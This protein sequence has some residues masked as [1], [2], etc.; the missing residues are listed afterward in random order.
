MQLQTIVNVEKPVF[1]IGYDKR[2]LMLGSCF[3]EN[4][5]GKL[6]YFK[7]DVD[8]N[9]CGIVYNPLSVV[10]VLNMLLDNRLFTENDLLQN[11]GKWVS[12]SHHGRFSA[13][14]SGNC[15]RKINERLEGAAAHLRMTDVLMITWGTSGVYRFRKDGKIVSNCHKFPASDFERFRLDID[16]I[17]KEYTDILLRLKRLRPGLNV[18]FTVS[19]IRHW[20]DGAHGNQLS[21]AVLLLAIDELTRL[22]DFV[23]YFPSYEIVMDELRDYRFY[24]EDML[25]IS[26]QGLEYIWERFKEI[27]ISPETQTWMTRIDKIN[28]TLLHRPSDP[29]S[30][31]SIRLRMKMA[32]EMDMIRKELG[33]RFGV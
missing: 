17:V 24:A 6:E 7:F 16:G 32:E 12:L 29:D 23:T 10:N 27:Y 33:M 19:P 14:D 18:V 28:K 22:F 9:P 3:V 1:R 20:K 25:H 26:P 15:L 11:D 21:K 4:I 8:V 2:I 13:T 5:G 31:D 30:E